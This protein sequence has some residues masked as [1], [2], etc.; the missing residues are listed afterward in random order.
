MSGAVHR[1]YAFVVWTETT[2]PFAAMLA[3]VWRS[4]SVFVTRN[5]TAADDGS[6][7]T[8]VLPCLPVSS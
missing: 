1:L 4:F 6:G 2:L 7:N 8:V 5:K 3:Y